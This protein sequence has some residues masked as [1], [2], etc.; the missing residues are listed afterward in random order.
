[1]LARWRSEVGFTRGSLA[2]FFLQPLALYVDDILAHRRARKQGIWDLQRT[3]VPH[4]AAR[5]GRGILWVQCMHQGPPLVGS[6]CIR[7]RHKGQFERRACVYHAERCRAAV[8]VV[9]GSVPLTS[10]NRPQTAFW[11]G[12]ALD[13][14]GQPSPRICPGRSR[15]VLPW[16]HTLYSPRVNTGPKHKALAQRQQPLGGPQRES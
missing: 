15:S 6:G 16:F 12:R 10:A 1:M 9:R 5:G 14:P 4:A 2:L 7:Q 3:P 11:F 13:S 8:P